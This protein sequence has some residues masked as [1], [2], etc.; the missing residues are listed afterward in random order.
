MLHLL[1]EGDIGLVSLK[2]NPRIGKHSESLPSGKETH[3]VFS[4]ELVLL[5][6]TALRPFSKTLDCGS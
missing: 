1:F 4:A 2:S 3:V 6:S 5:D